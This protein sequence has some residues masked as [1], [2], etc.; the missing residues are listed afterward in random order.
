MK[1][2]RHIAIIMDGNGRWA[3]SRGMMRIN[4]HERGA[5]VVRT[6]AEECSR[7][8][9]EQLTLYSFSEEN[10]RR[11]KLE[12]EFL[13]RLLKRFIVR[14][15]DTM[16]K[17]NMRFS[18]M[19]RVHRLPA[20]VRKEIKKSEEMTAGN[21][22]T[23]LTL[24]LSYGGR[25]ELVDAAKTLAEK[26]K[27]GDLAPEEITEEMI[28]ENMYQPDMPDPDLVIRTAGEMRLSN[29]LLWQVSYAEIYITDVLWPEFTAD[30]LNIAISDFNNRTRRY[31]GLVDPIKPAIG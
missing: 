14:E 18:A 9:V 25:A 21:T 3:K 31:G 11:P 12:I 19:G 26:V 10:W 29:F 22:G 17:N 30:D 15:R 23:R 13:M 8:G 16:M 5:E 24:A 20:N 7:L 4:G 6:V 1:V 2:P 28:S 27:S